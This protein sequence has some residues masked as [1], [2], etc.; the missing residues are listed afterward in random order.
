MHEH[1]DG[2]RRLPIGYDESSGA[3]TIGAREGGFPGMAQRRTFH[4]RWTRPG[5]P[6]PLDL[7]A[8]PDA[9]VAYDG[10]ELT[11]QAPD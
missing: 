5:E 7:E 1:D 4:L 9:T 8:R 3:L 6:R 11:V 2:R 10:S